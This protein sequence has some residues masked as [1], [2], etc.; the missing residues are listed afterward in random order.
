MNFRQIITVCCRF[1]LD[2]PTL[3]DEINVEG[4][5][6]KPIDLFVRLAAVNRF[7]FVNPEQLPAEPNIKAIAIL[8]GKKPSVQFET[9]ALDWKKLEEMIKQNAPECRGITLRG[10]VLAYKETTALRSRTQSHFSYRTSGKRVDR[11]SPRTIFVTIDPLTEK[12][13]EAAQLIADFVYGYGIWDEKA[14]V[15]LPQDDSTS[16]TMNMEQRQNLSQEMRHL[17]QQVLV[18]EQIPLAIMLMSQQQR[19]V[20][21]QAVF[22]QVL[23]ANNQQ[24]L[25]I[26]QQIAN[27]N[28]VI[29]FK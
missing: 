12:R 20:P 1:I 2:H 24:L 15:E 17:Q 21:R 26:V 6:V 28:P 9:T 16:V 3:D 27:D 7:L 29:R 25:G 8:I 19:L 23:R 13:A 14:K 5:R 22:G 10:R 11:T 4:E 18:Q